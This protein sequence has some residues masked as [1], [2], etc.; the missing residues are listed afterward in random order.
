MG[1]VPVLVEEQEKLAKA[2][3]LNEWVIDSIELLL[4][5]RHVSSAREDIEM[6]RVFYLDIDDNNEPVL[7]NIPEP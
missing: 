3:E 7:E 2:I 4:D 6:L 1:I 5:Y